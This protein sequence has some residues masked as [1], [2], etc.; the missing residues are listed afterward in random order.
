MIKGLEHFSHEEGLRQ[1]SLFSL[2]KSRLNRD[3][4][5]MYKHLTGDNEDMSARLFSVV[6]CDRTRSNPYK[7][8]YMKFHL[9]ARK[10]F[11]TVRVVKH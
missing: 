8:K 4:I 1:L 7:L 11:F 10:H 5:N 2:E 9:N 6:P 3:H